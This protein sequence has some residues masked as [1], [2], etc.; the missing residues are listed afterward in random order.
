[1]RIPETCP[2]GSV[3]I[4]TDPISGATVEEGDEVALFVC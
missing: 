2:G 4:E 3:V 1:V